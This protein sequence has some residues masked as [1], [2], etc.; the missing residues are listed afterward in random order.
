MMIARTALI[1]LLLGTAFGAQAAQAPRPVAQ[2]YVLTLRGA[3]DTLKAADLTPY[4][5]IVLSFAH[6]DANGQLVSGDT[7]TCMAGPNHTMVTTAD[8]QSA[9][10]LIHAGGRRAIVSLGGALIP[11]CAGDWA[12]LVGPARR[13][14]TVQALS[15]FADRFKIDGL[16]VDLESDL[17][18]KTVDAG[19]YTPF[20]KVLS[21][22][23]HARGKTLS[24]ATA[25]YAGGMIPIDSIPAFDRVGV[26]AYDNNAPGEEHASPADFK[27]E[28]YQW[29]GRGVAPDRLVVGLPFYGHGY[30]DYAVPQPY[31]DIVTAHTPGP[32][33][34]VVGQLCVGCS[35]ITF[36][37]PSTIT[38]KTSLAV[39]KVS[40]VMVWE[41]WQDTPDHGLTQALAAGEK[42][43][44]PYPKLP[45]TPAVQGTA[46]TRFKVSQWD[47]QGAAPVA[48]TDKAV[49]GGRTVRIVA[50]ITENPW[51]VSAGLPIASHLKKGQRIAIE[52]W[53]RVKADDPDTQFEVPVTIEGAAEP[54]PTLLTGKVTVTTAWRK[55][56]VTGV[57]SADVTPG[58]ANVEVLL[59]A[60]AK[61]V[62]IG[63]VTLV[64]PR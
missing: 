24:V 29:L 35:Y 62:E 58:S 55:V 5:D 39:R 6:P 14:A 9:I 32:Q 42:A 30:G 17:L 20:V 13:D 31:R 60:A 56:V 47:V 18:T 40:G 10:D 16:D 46:L 50:P 25:S 23:L 11:A 3:N 26:M 51:D 2:A 21:A 64:Q 43:V 48:A 61:T 28:M 59:G 44:V 45:A 37:S 41:L 8:L 12:D 19:N 52:L 49:P 36:N 54:Y 63:P 4:T 27:N 38:A 1:S 22:V 53:V 33:A 34:D 7:L 57:L 15:E